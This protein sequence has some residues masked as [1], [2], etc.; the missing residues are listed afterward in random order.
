MV[1]DTCIRKQLLIDTEYSIISSKQSL[2]FLWNYNL[3]F[4]KEFKGKSA[5]LPSDH[6]MTKLL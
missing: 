6:N 1:I 3:I 2:I 4:Y 5:L